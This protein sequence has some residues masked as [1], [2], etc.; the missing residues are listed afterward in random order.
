MSSGLICGEQSGRAALGGIKCLLR[1]GE[2]TGAFRASA[3]EDLP[4]PSLC[5]SVAF[6]LQDKLVSVVAVPSQLI[7]DAHSHSESIT[8]CCF[9]CAATT[10]IFIIEILLFITRMKIFLFHR[11][12]SCVDSGP[13]EDFLPSRILVASDMLLGILGLLLPAVFGM[14]RPCL[15]P[16]LG[17]HRALSGPAIRTA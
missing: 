1:V 13:S 14:A 11:S 10:Y 3:C 6:Y 8:Y 9:Y 2:A 16:F 12:F 7:S 5:P 15:F 4:Y 17:A